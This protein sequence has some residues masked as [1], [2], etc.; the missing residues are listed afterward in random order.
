MLPSAKSRARHAGALAAGSD[1]QL[2]GPRQRTPVNTGTAGWRIPSVL[3]GPSS[4]ETST[5]S[6][7]QSVM[8]FGGRDIDT[9]QIAGVEVPTTCRD[10][11]DDDVLKAAVDIVETHQV[12]EYTV[13]PVGGLKIRVGVHRP[14]RTYD[15]LRDELHALNV[16][17]TDHGVSDGVR[18][19]RLSLTHEAGETAAGSTQD[20]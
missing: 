12:T 16:P 18:R 11:I 2:D 17:V 8:E 15:T 13:S 19:L 1:G 20:P 7:Y 3:T 14:D 6:P 10:R 9:V 4:C 5:A